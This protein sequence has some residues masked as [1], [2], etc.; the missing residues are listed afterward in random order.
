MYSKKLNLMMALALFFLLVCVP[1]ESAGAG[2]QYQNR[3][4]R[5]EGIKA[6]PVAGYDIE[7]ISAL[8]DYKEEAARLPDWFK[9]KFYLREPS[10]V[11]L[12]VRE[13]DY[14]YYY[15]MDKVQ[16][17]EPWKPGFGNY[18]KWS[19]REVI[20]RLD[21]LDMYD[22][23]L[24]AR[25][26]KPEPRKIDRV[27]PVIFYHSR[28]PSAVNGY[29]FTFR[30]NGDARLIS[31]FYNRGAA[32]P[33]FTRRFRRQRGGR[34]FTVR[35]DSITSAEGQYKLVVKGYFLDTHQPI[36]E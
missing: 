27:A 11:Y 4:D 26:E 7:L 2:L 28:H 33:V 12:T 10:K 24:V 15:W 6:K 32:E 23:G 30:A 22:L 31:S 14:R 19:S 16:P 1:S 17:P 35:W 13:L 36:V 29:L 18:F 21:Q 25:L 9:V 3:G 8:V 34:P 5:Y 20:R